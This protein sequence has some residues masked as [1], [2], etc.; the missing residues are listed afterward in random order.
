[1]RPPS[2]RLPRAHGPLLFAILLVACGTA[3]DPVAEPWDRPVPGA[4]S[5]TEWSDQGFAFD[6][7]GASSP[8]ELL[9]RIERTESGIW[10][11]EAV[12]V[13]IAGTNASGTVVGYARTAFEAGPMRGVDLRF[14]MR[15]DTGAWEI[16]AIERRYHCAG[17]TATEL[18]Q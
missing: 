11:T 18:C 7:R 14:D 17:E 8:E 1:M 15:N 2:R 6:E 5:T 16:V 3:L 13:G 10:A 9:T 4:L 12:S